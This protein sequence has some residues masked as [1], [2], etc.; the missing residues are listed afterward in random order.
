[1]TPEQIILILI[2]AAV[3]FIGWSVTAGLYRREKDKNKDLQLENSD[4]IDRNLKLQ[5]ELS[6]SQKYNSGLNSRID[7]LNGMLKKKK[8]LL[9][10][11]D[12][13]I[14]KKYPCDQ[15]DEACYYHCTKGGQQPPE[16]EK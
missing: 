16:C 4:L 6:T 15:C 1:M 10:I 2:T 3:C 14:G 13:I 7:N 9:E 11:Q 12:R 8:E 5:K